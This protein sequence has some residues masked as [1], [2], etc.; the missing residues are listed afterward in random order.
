MARSCSLTRTANRLFKFHSVDRLGATRTLGSI[1]MLPVVTP[2]QPFKRKVL[3]QLGLMNAIGRHLDFA[4]FFC[5]CICEARIL[6]YGKTNLAP[7]FHYDN[8]LVVPINR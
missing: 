5:R 1:L 4:E 2:E 6:P 8:D 3:I 7:V